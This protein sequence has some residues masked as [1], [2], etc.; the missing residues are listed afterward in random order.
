MVVGLLDEMPST[1]DGCETS[2][3]DSHPI[4]ILPLYYPMHVFY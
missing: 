4:I 2:D 3:F 1:S